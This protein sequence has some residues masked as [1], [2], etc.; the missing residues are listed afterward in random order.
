MSTTVMHLR[1]QG[2]EPQSVIASGKKKFHALYRTWKYLQ[3][4]RVES[5]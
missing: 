5:P 1:Y 2:T 4:Q 3:I